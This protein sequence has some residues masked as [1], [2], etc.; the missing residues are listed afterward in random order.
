MIL[1]VRKSTSF[2]NLW[3]YCPVVR[4]CFLFSFL[5]F[6]GGGELHFKLHKLKFILF[7][8]SC[9]HNQKRPHSHSTKESLKTE[10]T[11]LFCSMVLGSREHEGKENLERVRLSPS[12]YNILLER[13]VAISRCYHD[14]CSNVVLLKLLVTS[15]MLLVG[16][17]LNWHS[18]GCG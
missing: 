7:T 18:F 10:Q 13:C 11:F 2:L 14:I 6:W 12:T 8:P 4:K 17:G 16:L 1:D 5:F 9:I 3:I 15:E